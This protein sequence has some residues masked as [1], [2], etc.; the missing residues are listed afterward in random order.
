MEE[1]DKKSTRSWFW[2]LFLNNQVVTG[3]L[4]VLLILLII[5]I[6]TKVSHLFTPVIQFVGIIG[7]PVIFAGILF[8]LLNPLVDK[9]EKK[10]I[11]RV[12]SISVIFIVII[13]LIV[14][15]IVILVPEIQRQTTSFLANWPSYWQT[16][17]GKW[18]ELLNHRFL[19]EYAPQIEQVSAN[20]MDSIG[21]LFE[22]FS[23]NAFRG[24]GSV[25]GAFTTVFLTVATG[26][27][28][29][30][31]LL[32]DGKSLGSYIEKF[33]PVKV[34]RPVMEVLEDINMQVSQ[35]IRGQLT[36]ALIVAIMFMIGFKAINLEFGVTLGILAGFLNLIPYLGSFLAM[37]P[38][39]ILGIVTSPFMLVKVLIVFSL[40]QFIEGRFVSP[41]V[42]GSQLKVHPVTIIFVLLTAGN[43]FGVVG[44]ILGVPG[45]ATIKVI[46]THIFDWYKEHSGLYDE[47]PQD[48]K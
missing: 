28:I 12:W 37:I 13:A 16:I 19:E 27:I 47:E 24:I 21:S 20:F 30:F 11:T 33:L 46:V 18:D 17:Q 4:V 39:V 34:R 45:Y 26:P 1:K 15:G 31:Y 6:F 42:L 22:N 43:L 3:L 2:K 25:I 38:A 48:T 7:S 8:Y 36:V 29:L 9:L 5:L 23:K 44:V 10:G 14:W 41:L 32:R 40:E 35:Y